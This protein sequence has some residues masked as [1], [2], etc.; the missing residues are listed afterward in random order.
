MHNTHGPTR[1]VSVPL[2]REKNSSHLSVANART[3]PHSVEDDGLVV[4]LG[5]DPQPPAERTDVRLE[6]SE[7]RTGELAPLDLADPGL[8]HVQAF[9]EALLRQRP[10]GADVG[11]LLRLDGVPEDFHSSAH[12]LL[13]EPLRDCIGTHLPP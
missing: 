8:T 10:G 1:S 9:R 5:D 11:E 2:H 7:L 12:A 4:E 13:V 6:C 3:T